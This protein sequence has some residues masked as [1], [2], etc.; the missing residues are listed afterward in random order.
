MAPAA[1][2][3]QRNRKGRVET[4]MIMRSTDGFN[5]ENCRAV[6]EVIEKRLE[7]IVTILSSKYQDNSALYDE[8]LSMVE[9]ALIRIALQRSC[10]V[11]KSAALFLGI[12]R[13]TLHSKMNKLGIET[14]EDNR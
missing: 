11:K 6:E 12:N 4:D 14:A 8:I 2:R 10:N 5:P 9:R 1:G 7:E 3:A 13:N